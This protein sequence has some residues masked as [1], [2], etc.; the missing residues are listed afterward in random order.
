MTAICITICIPH[1]A[2]LTAAHSAT[3]YLYDLTPYCYYLSSYYLL[4]LLEMLLNHMGLSGV[5]GRFV[6]QDPAKSEH[7][8]LYE[9]IKITRLIKPH[10]SMLR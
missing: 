4:Y 10:T 5:S 1:L 6:F 2:A 8:W 3:R 7:G 9:V